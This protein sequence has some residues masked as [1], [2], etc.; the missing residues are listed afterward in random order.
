MDSLLRSIAII[1]RNLTVTAIMTCLKTTAI[2]YITLRFS[3]TTALVAKTCCLTYC[4][5]STTVAFR[6]TKIAFSQTCRTRYTSLTSIS[7][8]Y[9]TRHLF[10]VAAYRTLFLLV[11]VRSNHRILYYNRWSIG[12]GILW[13]IG[14]YLGFICFGKIIP[15]IDKP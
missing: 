7:F 5:A 4:H 6:T 3:R 1:T 15:Y 2:T 10:C 8:A 14:V 13:M 11:V 9:R 12:R